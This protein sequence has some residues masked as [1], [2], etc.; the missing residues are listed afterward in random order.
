MSFQ[1]INK[2][3]QGDVFYAFYG[4]ISIFIFCTYGFSVIN[5]FLFEKKKQTGEPGF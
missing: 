3:Q 1:T 4:C 2:A 5:G